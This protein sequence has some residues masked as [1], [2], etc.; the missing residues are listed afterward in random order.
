MKGVGLDRID[1]ARWTPAQQQQ[2]R[3]AEHQSPDGGDQD[4]A[5]RLD[6]VL[7]RQMLPGRNVEEPLVHLEHG[8][9]HGSDHQSADSSNQRRQQDEARFMR[10]Y[11][12]P[13]PSRRLNETETCK[14]S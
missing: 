10:A 2:E 6:L 4:G 8:G 7:A 5:Q 13:E 9:S 12:S 11:E 3:K 14:H 1:L